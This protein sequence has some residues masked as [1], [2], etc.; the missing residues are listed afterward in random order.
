MALIARCAG[1]LSLDGL[2]TA[3]LAGHTSSLV[4]AVGVRAETTV[5]AGSLTQRVVE[6]ADTAHEAL[7]GAQEVLETCN[8]VL[9]AG[10]PLLQHV[11]LAGLA[12][13]AHGL[14][15]GIVVLA[16]ITSLAVDRAAGLVLEFAHTTVLAG[17]RID[18]VL[19]LA[20]LQQPPI[21]TILFL[22]TY[23][24]LEAGQLSLD[25]DV[26]TSR[27]RIAAELT[28]QRLETTCNHIQINRR[29]GGRSMLTDFAAGTLHSAR[30][31]V[32]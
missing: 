29:N 9:V 12:L 23:R 22:L 4:G 24:T 11:E 30:G 27:A 32:V 21:T 1:D 15:R 19:P 14:A 18:L 7:R 10:C 26:A 5:L 28:E 13:L 3:P 20:K 8:R 6:L 17:R 16:L 31:V 2:R 25:V